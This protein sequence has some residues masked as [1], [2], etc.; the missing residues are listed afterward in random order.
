VAL[1]VRA[2]RRGRRARKLMRLATRSTPTDW[3]SDR[4]A[5]VGIKL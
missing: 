5:P 1:G 3:I 4:L 2:D